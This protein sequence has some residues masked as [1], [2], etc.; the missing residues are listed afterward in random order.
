MYIL[1]IFYN[2]YSIYIL[3]VIRFVIYELWNKYQIRSTMVHFPG[4]MSLQSSGEIN[5]LISQYGTGW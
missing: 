5:N 4:F 2:I 1:Y 3:F